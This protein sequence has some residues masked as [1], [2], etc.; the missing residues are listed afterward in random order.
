MHDKGLH[1]RRGPGGRDRPG[2]LCSSD[3]LPVPAGKVKTVR[4]SRAE[5]Y[6]LFCLFTIAVE[7]KNPFWQYIGDK[8]S[9]II[10]F[11]H[12]LVGFYVSRVNLWDHFILANLLPLVVMIITTGVSYV[13][14][15]LYV[16]IKM[17]RCTII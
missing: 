9:I 16:K 15:N 5:K 6:E 13:I 1:H 11:I 17:L 10:F 3:L 8:L 12:P 4:I 7:R 2:C 14:Y